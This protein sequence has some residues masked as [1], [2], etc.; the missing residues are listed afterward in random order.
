M[1]SEILDDY[2]EGTFTATIRGSSADADPLITS[3][4]ANYTKI[5]R[6]V[7]IGIAYEAVNTTGYSGNFTITGLPFAVLAHR[8]IFAI[9]LY[10]MATFSSDAVVGVVPASATTIE[11]QNMR[12]NTTWEEVTHNAGAGGYGW[13][14][15][16]YI[17]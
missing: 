11:V 17:S 9:A 1:T 12:S 15:G 16:T 8:S 4:V 3:S 6:N 2:E 5:G 7:T 14:M 10:N 13:V